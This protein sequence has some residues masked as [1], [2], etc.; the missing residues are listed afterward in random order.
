MDCSASITLIANVEPYIKNLEYTMEG[1]F[2]CLKAMHM[3][4]VLSLNCYQTLRPFHADCTYDVNV[5]STPNVKNNTSLKQF[6]PY[7]KL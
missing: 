6:N 3:I 2:K 1:Y 7:I 4:V 5:T